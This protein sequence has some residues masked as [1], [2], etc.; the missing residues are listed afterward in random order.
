MPYRS[1][2]DVDRGVMVTIETA[3]TMGTVMPA[4][5]QFFRNFNTT[6]RTILTCA[7]RFDWDHQQTSIYG[8]ICQ[9]R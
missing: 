8:F 7:G 6:I 4:F 5:M 9:Y 1:I 2:F 3:S